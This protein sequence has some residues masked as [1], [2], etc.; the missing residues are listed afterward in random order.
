MM[1]RMW[2]GG[3]IKI[4]RKWLTLR[5]GHS[6]IEE[7]EI[8]KFLINRTQ[9]ES[10]TCWGRSSFNLRDCKKMMMW[11]W[12]F[13]TSWR[14]STARCPSESWETGV[15]VMEVTIYL[16]T[17][18]TRSIITS[19]K[20]L[21]KW[22]SIVKTLIRGHLKSISLRWSSILRKRRMKYSPCSRTSL[23]SLP[24]ISIRTNLSL[25]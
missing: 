19:T 15:M 16:V 12:I 22:I 13:K 8:R 9:R 25:F 23:D 24:T 5:A 20:R 21:R 2:L 17:S 1:V 11:T 6:R 14:Q 7:V 4:R 3:G 18:S 10:S